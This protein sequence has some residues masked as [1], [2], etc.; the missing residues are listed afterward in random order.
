[1][2]KVTC[3]RYTVEFKAKVAREAI[4]GDGAALLIV[5]EEVTDVELGRHAIHRLE[6]ALDRAQER[7]RRT[8]R[9]MDRAA[10]HPSRARR[11]DAV[12][13]L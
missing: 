8:F 11:C 5:N 13:R 1:M 12:P 10:R 6:A 3:K 4:R 7:R 9:A 2:G